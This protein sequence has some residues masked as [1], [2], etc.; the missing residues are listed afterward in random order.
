[1]RREPPLPEKKRRGAAS[2]AERLLAY[3]SVVCS[4]SVDGSSTIDVDSLAVITGSSASA[5]REAVAG[6]EGAG[7]IFVSR[8]TGEAM[9]VSLSAEARDNAARQRA[10][11]HLR[12]RT[13]V[14]GH[15]LERSLHQLMAVR[16]E[17]ETLGAAAEAAALSKTIGYVQNALASLKVPDAP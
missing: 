10:V 2:P 11:A 5:I 6:L 1:M 8:S 12:S 16:G 17:F 13:S 15:G 4:K 14:A 7:N 3:F 9:S